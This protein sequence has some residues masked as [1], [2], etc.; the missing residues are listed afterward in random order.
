MAGHDQAALWG[1]GFWVLDIH[2]VSIFTLI[3]HVILPGRV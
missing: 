3:F 2:R 1:M